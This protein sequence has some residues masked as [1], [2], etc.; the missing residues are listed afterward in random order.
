MSRPHPQRLGLRARASAVFGLGALGVSSLLA[1]ATYE[2][3]RT[4]LV[5]ERERTAVRAAYFDAA[6]VRQGLGSDASGIVDVLRSLDTGQARRPLIYRDGQWYAR[7]ADTGFT[8]AVPAA[9]QRLARSGTPGVQRVSLN[10]TPT[11]VIAVPLASAGAEYYEL[12]DQ[13]ELARTLRQLSGTLVAVAL[14]TTVAAGLLGQWVSRRIL[15]PLGSVAGAARRIAG[16]DLAARLAQTRDPDLAPLTAA[17][18]DMVDELAQSIERDRRF[19]ADVSHE[20]R[21]P[22]QTLSLASSVLHGRAGSL[23]PRSAAA[24]ELVVAEVG[25]F[26]TLVS[27]LLELARSEQPAELAPV[28]VDGLLRRVAAR[29]G[30]P[31]ERVEV[32][33]GLVWPLDARRFE[34]VVANLLEN[35]GRH[36]GGATAVTCVVDGDRLRLDVDDQGPGVPEEERGLIFDRFGRGRRASARGGAGVEGTGLGLALVAQHVAAHGGSVAVLDRP[37]GGARF[38]VTVPRGAS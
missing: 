38:E 10:G 32:P 19:A 4:S 18:N 13:S 20:L 29:H 7:S 36:A 25:R 12:S 16:G 28:P 24:A 22:L 34:R 37:G 31:P 26:E 8:A 23:D 5:A 21:S 2:L 3:T 14:L 15:R 35:A 30:V 33:G 11:L 17:F 1:T 9:L 27:D 6:V